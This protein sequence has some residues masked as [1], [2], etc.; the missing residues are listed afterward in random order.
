MTNSNRPDTLAGPDFICIGAQK[1]GTTWLYDQLAHHP[2][3]WLPVIKELHYFNFAQPNALLAGKEGYPW[4]SPLERMRF[5]KQR[6]DMETLKWL[7]RY[8]F[9]AKSS[10]WYRNLFPRIDGKVSGELT[11]AYSTLDER[12]VDLVKS[13]VSERCRILLIIRDPV[14]RAWSG[15]KMNYRWTGE[16]VTQEEIEGLRARIG[17]NTVRLRSEYS[18]IIPRWK[19][20]FPDRF[21]LL[22]YEDLKAA[23]E[24][25]FKHVCSLLGISQDYIPDTLHKRSNED[26]EGISMPKVAREILEEMLVSEIEHFKAVRDEYLREEAQWLSR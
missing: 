16:D 10:S 3:V 22:F 26:R 6:P 2:Q 4:G 13:T 9:G 1:A 25:F 12:G 18:K 21:S 8:N 17:S 5:L 20:R 7:L 14:E 24:A 15:V 23:P 11:P 19:E